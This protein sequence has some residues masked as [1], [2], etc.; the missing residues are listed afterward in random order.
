MSGY[1][2]FRAVNEFPTMTSMSDMSP[3]GA[4]KHLPSYSGENTD[5]VQAIIPLKLTG[6]FNSAARLTRYYWNCFRSNSSVES[7]TETLLRNKFELRVWGAF[8]FS[9]LAFFVLYHNGGASVLLS[10]GSS[11]SLFSHMVVWYSVH[12]KQSAAGISMQMFFARIV[13]SVARLHSIIF[14][15]GYLPLDK[16]GEGLYQIIEIL[17]FLAI[18]GLVVYVKVKLQDTISQESLCLPMLI[19]PA[20]SAAVFMH[21]DLNQNL[22]ADWAWAFALYLESV[23]ALPQLIMF[24]SHRKVDDAVTH[25]LAAQVLMKLISVV[26]WISSW[27][28]LNYE[29]GILSNYVGHFVM[30]VQVAQIVISADFAYKYVECVIKGRSFDAMVAIDCV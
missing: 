19:L 14:Y 16:S 5:I 28:E 11:V 26:F 8:L 2:R 25:F 7:M 1:T 15:S 23:V 4:V 12:S 29:G 6:Y 22:L 10:I 27:T 30:L 3:M 9:L 24:Y 20:F 17:N 18:V 21:S 13:I